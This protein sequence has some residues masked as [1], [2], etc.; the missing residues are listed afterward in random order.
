MIAHGKVT[1]RVTDTDARL[2]VR[3]I[4]TESALA[5]S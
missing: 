1:L 4:T 5:C 2:T 3:P